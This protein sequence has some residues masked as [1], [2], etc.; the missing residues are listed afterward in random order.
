[1]PLRKYSGFQPP[2]V[3]SAESKGTEKIVLVVVV[4]TA[5]VVLVLAKIYGMYVILFSSIILFS[6]HHN[7]MDEALY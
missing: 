7:P 5:A 4:V 1:M 2:D 6:P 3:E